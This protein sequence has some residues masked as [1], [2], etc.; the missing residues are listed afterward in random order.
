M[1]KTENW[2]RFTGQT[3]N[4]AFRL[5]QYL[6]G[7]AQDAVFLAENK[8][9]T[10][11][12]VA[13]KLVS[14]KPANATRQLKRWQLAAKLSHP[15]L[16]R[17]MESGRCELEGVALLYLAMEYAEE[18]LAQILPQ[19]AL[20][21]EET[22]EFLVPLLETLAFLHNAGFVHGHL[23]P[24]NV[25][26]VNDQLKFSSDGIVK[27]NELTGQ[28]KRGPYDSPEAVT[29]TTSPAGDVWALGMVIVEALTQQL[30]R[31]AASSASDDKSID[32]EIPASIP[33]PFQEIARNCLRAD[34]QRRW[35]VARIL[36]RLQAASEILEEQ[37]PPRPEP[38]A[39][40]GF[41]ILLTA[42]AAVAIVVAIVMRDS[43]STSSQGPSRQEPQAV[44]SQPASAPVSSTAPA[45]SQPASPQTAKPQVPPA[46]V[47]KRQ[48]EAPRPEAPKPTRAKHEPQPQAVSS[49]ATTDESGDTTSGVVRRVVP[50]VP[51][52]ARNTIHGKVRVR[53]RV[54]VDTAGHVTGV[55]F[56]THGPSDYFARLAETA[57]Q[58]WQFVPAQTNGQ[59]TASAW[60]I[61][62]AFGRKVTEVYP[63]R[64]N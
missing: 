8:S 31:T 42:A 37:A 13:I 61:K 21:A 29:M 45:S 7:S 17:L 59:N 9:Q 50:T 48:A 58:Q 20:T 23:S 30:P 40:R 33:E 55:T 25:L 49:S 32:P 47:A 26:V 18:N 4:G 16:L 6:G 54:A 24:A 43:H 19:R 12:R 38:S 57:A 60:V 1:A 11:S 46:V 63:T 53:V 62:F 5:E 28:T 27:I 2:Q 52:S 10:P 3:V 39:K 15:R 51:Q 41:L 34:P 44:A 22:K 56:I 14:A 64:A 36:A 35:S